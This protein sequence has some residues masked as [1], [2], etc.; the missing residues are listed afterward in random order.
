MMFRAQSISP[1]LQDKILNYEQAFWKSKN[2][3]LTGGVNCEE[4][5]ASDAEEKDLSH[6]S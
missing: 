2:A 6:F 5:G 1:Q 4:A 3:D